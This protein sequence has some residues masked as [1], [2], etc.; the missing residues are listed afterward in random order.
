ME[1]LLSFNFVQLSTEDKNLLRKMVRIQRLQ[2][3]KDALAKAKSSELI[4]KLGERGDEA[5]RYLG[6]IVSISKRN[7]DLFWQILD[8]W[9]LPFCLA[10]LLYP[11]ELQ[12]SDHAHQVVSN[13]G[14]ILLFERL[15]S[16]APRD[17]SAT[18]V[19]QVDEDGCIH[20]LSRSLSLRFQ[21]EH[22]QRK[23]VEWKC[24]PGEAAVR[25]VD[26]DEPGFSVPV[27][28]R[29]NP[30]FTLT[31]LTSSQ[32]LG[33]PILEE[34]AIF[35]KPVNRIIGDYDETAQGDYGSLPLERSLG[36]AQDLLN[37]LWPEALEWAETLIPAFVDLGSPPDQIRL[38]SSYEPSS[39][40]FLSRVE[41]HFLH[42][43]DLVHETQHQRLLLFAGPPHFKSWEDLRPVYIS[44]YRP[45]P[46]PLR[47]LI[48][49][50]HAFLA[51]NEVRKRI[52]E[53]KQS[54]LAINLMAELHFDNLFAFRTILEHEGFSEVCKGLF[55]QMAYTIAEH[56]LLVRSS[57]T[58]K[59]QRA[60]DDKICRH[61]AMVQKQATEAKT[62][63]KNASPLY[64]NWDET[65]RLAA[66]YT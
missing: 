15:L 3:L 40:V 28:T 11:D 52:V 66:S 36:Q 25:L 16:D 61:I 20:G 7:T 46:R 34:K 42:A 43:E 57:T 17:G 33:L 64:R 37:D 47:G 26:E 5:I 21:N 44:P 2:I 49:G 13:L 10:R 14:A 31:P 19:T 32:I 23:R 60:C 50:L 12:D 65:A 55:K 30:H 38:S 18:Y 59:I 56:H 62:E 45:D 35:G 6:E 22:F 24:S 48:I 27:P 29:D 41:N 1:K 9:P 39:P 53:L 58:A 63:L 8:H 54:P 4:D 51:V